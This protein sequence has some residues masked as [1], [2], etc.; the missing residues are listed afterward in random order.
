MSQPKAHSQLVVEGKDDQHVVWGLC[1]AHYVPEV[2]AVKIASTQ[3]DSVDG[4]IDELLRG[5]PVRLKAPGLQNLGI[6]VDADTNVTARWQALLSRLSDAG[7]TD[8]PVD[9]AVG[10]TIIEQ[11]DKPK[12]GIWLMPNN[13]QTGMIEDFA[14]YLIPE[15]DALISVANRALDEIEALRLHRYP[16][17]HRPKAFIHTWLAWQDRPGRP[18]GQSITA[19]VLRPDSTLAIEFVGWLRRLFVE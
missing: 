17:L 14:T 19:R 2:F 13:N 5:L 16:N 7:Y 1:E 4:G 12:V 9:P 10:G 6:V 11:E 8:L 15:G 18:M 3:E